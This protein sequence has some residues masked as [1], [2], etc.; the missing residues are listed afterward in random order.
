MHSLDEFRPISKWFKEL[1]EDFE[2][3][4]LG[5]DKEKGAVIEARKR[6]LPVSNF[7]ARPRPR[8]NKSN[9]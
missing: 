5:E 7:E 8:L 4:Y 9:K 6:K 2:G 1:E 3:L